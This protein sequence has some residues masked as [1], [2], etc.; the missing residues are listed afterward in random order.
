MTVVFYEVG[1]PVATRHGAG[2]PSPMLAPIA[3][4]GTGPPRM[5]A[6]GRC[7]AIPGSKPTCHSRAHQA[8]A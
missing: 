8:V 3:V 2:L 6:R 4:E 7:S 1:L 5:D